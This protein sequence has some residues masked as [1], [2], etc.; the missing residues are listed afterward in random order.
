MKFSIDRVTILAIV[1]PIPMIT[2]LS[3]ITFIQKNVFVDK[4]SL[5][6]QR[7]QHLAN[8][9]IDRDRTAWLQTFSKI[10]SN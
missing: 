6:I 7:V 1:I 8:T 2:L 3:T 4:T 5:I 9:L 10:L